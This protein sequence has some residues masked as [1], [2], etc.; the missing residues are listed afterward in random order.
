MPLEDVTFTH[1]SVSINLYNILQK[2]IGRA[3]VIKTKFRKT[4]GVG[5]ENNGT[6]TVFETKENNRLA[7]TEYEIAEPSTQ[8]KGVVHFKT[9]GT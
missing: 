8:V 2:K 4:D 5:F 1:S 3:S 6:R 9:N 7:L